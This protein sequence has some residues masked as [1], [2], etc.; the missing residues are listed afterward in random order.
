MK[1]L[2]FAANIIIF[3]VFGFFSIF[4]QAQNT[5]F[6]FDFVAGKTA[7]GYTQITEKRVYGKETGFGF[8]PSLNV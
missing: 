3:F 8:E 1:R 2:F 4:A 7:A 6:K 5:S